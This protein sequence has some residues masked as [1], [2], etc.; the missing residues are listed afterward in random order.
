MEQKQPNYSWAIIVAGALI[1][2]AILASNWGNFTAP[3]PTETLEAETFELVRPLDDADHYRG[4]PL[5]RFVIVEFSDLECPFCKIYHYELEKVV[6][7]FPDDVAVVFR[8]FP[9]AGL[10]KKAEAE[11]VAAECAAQ[12]GGD[13]TF[14]N[15][16]DR[17]FEAT[18]SNDGLDLALLPRFATDLGINGTAFAACTTG[19]D[20]ADAV[21]EDLAEAKKIGIRGTPGSIIID[22]ETGETITSFVG[23]RPA[24]QLIPLIE[25]LLAQ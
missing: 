22:T 12:L 2:G 6:T 4:S 17:I 14:W 25:S 18:T 19:R 9:I 3:A 1:A 21:A 24:D 10:H 23:A 15:Y 13:D 7:A 11:A 5:A 8:H 20:A 16:L